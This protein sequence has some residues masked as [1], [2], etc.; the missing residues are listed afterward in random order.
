MRRD[1]RDRPDDYYQ[2][3]RHRDDPY[4][5][6]N[7][8]RD[9]YRGDSYGRDYHGDRREPPR[10]DSHG[11]GYGYDNRREND[12][13]RD[14]SHDHHDHGHDHGKQ[15]NDKH[16][17]DLPDEIQV[18]IERISKFMEQKKTKSLL[19]ALKVQSEYVA[20]ANRVNKKEFIFALQNFSAEGLK[21]DEKEAQRIA[22]HYSF[23]HSTGVE[24]VN[25]DDV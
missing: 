21:L 12:Y 22:D 13:G 3:D 10:R 20:R 23:K 11:P 7:Y 8:G 9:S 19:E 6:D 17:H 25:I 14:H 1:P 18:L 2:G 15:Q 5:R 16:S 4:H 24:Y